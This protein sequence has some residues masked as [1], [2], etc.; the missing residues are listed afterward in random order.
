MTYRRSKPD[1][2][3]LGSLAGKTAL[4]CEKF[5]AE[6]PCLE[7]TGGQTTSGKLRGIGSYQRRA[8]FHNQPVMTFSL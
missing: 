5:A 8:V 3:S 1:N 4:Q 7:F 6:I 2:A